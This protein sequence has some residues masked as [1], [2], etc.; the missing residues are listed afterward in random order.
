MFR[1][2]K[3][4][5]KEGKCHRD[6]DLP[7]IDHIYGTKKWFK[8]GLLHRDGDFPAIEYFNSTK[9]WYKNGKCHRDGD[10]P[11]VICANGTKKWLKNG[12]YHRD[13]DLPAVEYSDG[14]KYWYKEGKLYREGNLSAIEDINGNAKDLNEESGYLDFLDL[15]YIQFNVINK[16]NVYLSSD[17]AKPVIPIT[18]ILQ[19]FILRA[20]ISN[21]VTFCSAVESG[22][23]GNGAK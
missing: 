10:K 17:R 20:L 15:I 13:G 4:W 9:K 16:M 23:V 6:G 21:L 19:K 14:T 2:N 3:E 1:W 11:A 12:K 22:C 5:Y 7:A 18:A 8:E